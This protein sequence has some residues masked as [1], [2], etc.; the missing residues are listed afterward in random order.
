MR[1]VILAMGTRG[2][3]QPCV[4]LGLALMRAGHTVRLAAPDDQEAFVRDWGL[5]FFPLGVNMHE[6]Q[7]TVTG[8]RLL[9][10]GSNVFAGLRE[11]VRLFLPF[12]EQ[13]MESTWQACQGA[14]AILF[15]TLG[16]GGYHVAEKLGIPCAWAVIVPAFTRTHAFP[17]LIAPVLPLGGGY[18]WLTHLLFE[19]FTQQSTGRFV[20]RWRR[21]RLDLPPLP[22]HSWPYDSLHGRPVPKLYGYSPTVI[23]RPR[24]WGP[25]AHVTGYWFLDHPPEWRPPAHLVDFLDAGP[26]P[27][28]VGFGS[29]RPANADQTT[30]VVLEALRASGQRGLLAASWG[31]LAQ[32]D[33]PEDVLMVESVPHDW[34]FPRVAAV[35]HHGG[36]GT[37]AA[38]LRAGVPSIVVPFGADQPFWAARVHQLGAGPSPIPYKKLTVERLT[39]ALRAA[40]SSE[41]M[42]QRA[43]GLRERLRSENGVGRAVEILEPYLRMRQGL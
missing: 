29:L 27:V 11:M 4:A 26:P 20:N 21:E 5:D 16:M 31:A 34:L 3:V 41:T 22:L 13:M 28:Y 18:N 40:T 19:Q 9:K 35:V 36:A 43:A 12:L 39:N 2:D 24:D 1:I 37:T 6:L 8:Q 23:P 42:R 10:T 17:S 38:G 15:S 7:Q 30:G 25:N 33:L 32:S 14:E